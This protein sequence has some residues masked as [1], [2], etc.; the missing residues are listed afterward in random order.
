MKA[1]LTLLGVVA[2]FVSFACSSDGGGTSEDAYGED[3]VMSAETAEALGGDP[4]IRD[5]LTEVLREYFGGLRAPRYKVLEEWEALGFDPNTNPLESAR[6]GSDPGG[7][8]ASAILADNRRVWS[9]ELAALDAGEVNDLGPWERRRWM[10]RSWRELKAQRGA[11]GE[12]EFE[13]RASALF[14]ERSPG[15]DEAAQIYVPSCARC[16]G[17]EGEGDGVLSHRQLPKPRN[18]DYGVFKFVGVDGGSKPLRIDIVRTLERGL[19]GTAMPAFKEM[20]LAELGALA[21][22]VRFLSIRGEVERLVVSEWVRDLV[23]P[24]DS[25][26][27]MYELVWERW[28]DAVECVQHAEAP[29]LDAD[30]RRLALGDAVFHDQQRGNCMSCHGDDGKGNGEAAIRIEAN[31]K[32]YPLLR[33]DWGA[34]NLPHDLTDGVFR[35]GS[36]REDVYL[37]IQCGIPGTPMPAVGQS[38]NA[39]GGPLLSEEEKWALVDYV[40]SLSGQ[41]PFGGS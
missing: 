7:P 17:R 18:F 28:L 20:S 37:R 21:D 14:I 23:R 22:Y 9:S 19:P 40:L 10:N 4:A 8:T 27:E 33:D 2:L 16:H 5:E 26:A 29:A 12:A 3:F 34:V 15:L 13:R 38:I 41:G 32:S 11:L 31:G 1:Q 24:R 30:P 39:D 6:A 25:I 36:R 35:G